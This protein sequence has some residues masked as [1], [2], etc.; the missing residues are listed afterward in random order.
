[1]RYLLTV[2]SSS[3]TSYF[4][5]GKGGWS[6]ILI[7]RF[8]KTFTFGIDFA[9]SALGFERAPSIGENFF[10]DL[11]LRSSARDEIDAFGTV[12]ARYYIS[13]LGLC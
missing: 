2:Y 10:L 1:M 13:S 4:S 12:V 8:L 5:S 3:W 7:F 6:L 11:A 9:A